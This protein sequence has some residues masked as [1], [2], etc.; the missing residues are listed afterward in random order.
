MY[1]TF[2]RSELIKRGSEERGV[3]L[4]AGVHL[5]ELVK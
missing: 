2:I 4:E 5:E 1:L 3:S